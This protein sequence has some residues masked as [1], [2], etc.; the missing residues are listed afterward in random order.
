MLGM[1]YTMLCYLYPLH[2]LY[3]SRYKS[4]RPSYTVHAIALEAAFRET[5]NEDP[6]KK[7]AR[8]RSC[9]VSPGDCPI[10]LLTANTDN[11]AR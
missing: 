4:S 11:R 1:C 5:R 10:A 2:R 8:P 9:I 7:P 6:E 3:L